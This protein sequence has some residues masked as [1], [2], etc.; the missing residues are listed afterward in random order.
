MKTLI[1]LFYE[2]YRPRQR[3]YNLRFQMRE[4]NECMIR[5]YQR[6]KE[7]IKVTE[8]DRDTAFSKATKELIR[9]YPVEGGTNGKSRF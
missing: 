3:R 8:D 1:D 9:R 7:V 2:T 5:I 4:R 6:E